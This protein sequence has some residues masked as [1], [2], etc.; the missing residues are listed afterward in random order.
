MNFLFEYFLFFAKIFTAV[1]GTLVVVLGMVAILN[2][3]TAKDKEKITIKKLNEKY[4]GLREELSGIIFSKEEQKA[5]KKEEKEKAKLEKKKAKEK[6]Q[7]RRI[8][9]LNF[10]GD[11]KATAV[12]NLREEVTA[13]LT[14]ARPED[15]VLVCVESS[16]G[17]VNNYG[18]A[19]SQLKR[20]RDQKLNLIVAVDKIAASG[21][22]LM[23]SV[24][25]KIIAA[26]FAIIGSIGVVAQLP[27][28]NKLLKKC[29]IDFEQITAGEYKRTLSLFGENTEKGRAK[30]KEEVEETHLLFKSFVGE[31]RPEVD[32]KKVSTGE[33]W[34]GTDA[35]KLNLVDE[36]LTSDDYLLKAKETCDLYQ[37]SYLAKKK[38]GEKIS[39]FLKVMMRNM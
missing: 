8:F 33:Y 29:H 10:D 18:L 11:I 5:R 15:E 3:S 2:R 32:L 20:I 25:H 39:S 1:I 22:Y 35:K 14:I 17:V 7:R 6:E 4:D 23:A 36:L 26:P 16:G 28:F 24:A 34:Y 9:V 19:A 38:W 12:E 13:I 37:I 31:C 30:A 21:G 27:N